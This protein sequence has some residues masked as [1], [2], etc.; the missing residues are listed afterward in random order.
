MSSWNVANNLE[1]R[2][3]CTSRSQEVRDL[4][5]RAS[6]RTL[7][8]PWPCPALSRDSFYALPVRLR[9]CLPDQVMSRV[10]MTVR[11]STFGCFRTCLCTDYI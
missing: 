6:Q 5:F 8:V 7:T 9:A 2:S 3:R 10:H 1:L 4:V 11:A